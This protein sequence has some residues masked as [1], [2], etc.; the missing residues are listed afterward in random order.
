MIW[1]DKFTEQANEII[2]NLFKKEKFVGIHLRNGPD[3]ENACNNVD[4]YHSY[5]ASPQCLEDIGRKVDRNLCFPTN[6]IILKDLE[7]ILVKKLNK[8]VKNIY[9]AT[10]KSSM[11]SEINFHFKN[12]IPNLNVVH[13]DP[14]SPMIDLIILGKSEWFVGNCVSSFTSFV[15]RERD[16][17][18]LKST[19]WSLE[20]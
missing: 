18:R 6:D 7:N 12:L 8:T 2:A 13:H 1:S 11:I 19:F 4:E 3:W 16:I 9:I 17:Q 10:D 15:K 5:M 14:L 20:V